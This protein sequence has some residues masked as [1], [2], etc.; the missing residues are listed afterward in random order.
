VRNMPDWMRACDLMIT[1]AGPGTIAE[2]LC[3]RVPLLLTSHLPGQERGNVDFVVDTG[4]G[5]YVPRVADMV[6]A[7]RELSQPG[8]GSLAAMREALRHAARPHA[9]A[10][11]AELIVRLAA[12]GVAA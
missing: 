9:T 2:A 5:R 10:Q 11:I 7:V 8:S 1:K 4:A 3:S 6:D 12:A